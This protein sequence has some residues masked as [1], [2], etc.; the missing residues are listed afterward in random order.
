[1]GGRTQK[2]GSRKIARERIET[3][4]LQAAAFFPEEPEWSRRCVQLARKI[5]MRQRI[6]IDRRLRRQFCRRCNAFL[7]P[8]VNMRVRIHRGR[9]VVTCLACGHRARYPARRSSRG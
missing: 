9:V 8:G 4:F 2:A 6:R 7:V 5:A 1:M 3:L